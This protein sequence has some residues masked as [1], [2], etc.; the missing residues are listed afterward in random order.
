L[1]S[2]DA[3]FFLSALFFKILRGVGF[4]TDLPRSKVTDF[5]AGGAVVL[6]SVYRARATGGL[7]PPLKNV[8][9]IYLTWKLT[10]GQ[11]PPPRYRQI[12]LGLLRPHWLVVRVWSILGGV[13]S[14]QI[15]CCHPGSCQ[16]CWFC[17]VPSPRARNC[18]FCKVSCGHLPCCS[19]CSG[20][21]SYWSHANWRDLRVAC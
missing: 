16:E 6:P 8:I 3:G 9:Q 12:P 5:L 15:S 18:T 17:N 14:V 13:Q 4:A 1:A 10:T 2:W 11:L 20:S 21:C 7:S 19:Y